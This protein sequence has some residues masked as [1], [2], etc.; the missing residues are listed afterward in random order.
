MTPCRLLRVHVL[1][2]EKETAEEDFFDQLERFGGG[3]CASK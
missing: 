1:A 2:D 3:G